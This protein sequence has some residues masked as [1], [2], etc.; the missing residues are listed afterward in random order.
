MWEWPRSK[1][2][3]GSG[4]GTKPEVGVT[5]EQSQKW[6]W[7]RNKAGGGSGL[8]TKPEVGVA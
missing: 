7:P 2:R 8:G 5:Q 4:L 3:V 1:A 6:E